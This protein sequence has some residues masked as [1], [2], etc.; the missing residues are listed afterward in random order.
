MRECEHSRKEVGNERRK[1]EGERERRVGW[2]K[3]K[4]EEV[5]VAREKKRES[6]PLPGWLVHPRLVHEENGFFSFLFRCLIRR[7]MWIHIT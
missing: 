3:D 7:R 2:T 6:T 5:R 1:R 4:R